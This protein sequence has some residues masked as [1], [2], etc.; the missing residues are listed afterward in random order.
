[1]VREWSKADFPNPY[2]AHYF[3][4]FAELMAPFPKHP[5]LT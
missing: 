5:N 1:M 4:K 3:G 2:D